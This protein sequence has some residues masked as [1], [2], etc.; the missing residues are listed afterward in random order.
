MRVYA[1]PDF[2][3][4]ASLSSSLPASSPR[5]FTPSLAKDNASFSDLDTSPPI[6]IVVV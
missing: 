4:A 3:I 6:L 1:V 5:R 2:F